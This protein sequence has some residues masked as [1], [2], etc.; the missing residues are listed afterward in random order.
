MTPTLQYT[1]GQWDCAW[2]SIWL[3]WLVGVYKSTPPTDQDGWPRALR[4][5]PYHVA[6]DVSSRWP[7]VGGQ[8]TGG[9]MYN[10]HGARTIQQ[11]LNTNKV[12]LQKNNNSSLTSG[13]NIMNI[14]FTHSI[15]SQPPPWYTQCDNIATVITVCKKP[16]KQQKIYHFPI[17]ATKIKIVPGIV[18]GSTVPGW[19]MQILTRI[20]SV[21]VRNK[22]YKNIQN[23]DAEMPWE[24]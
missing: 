4:E 13:K 7:D 16:M 3:I 9:A 20:L 2:A 17:L 22:V 19:S 6:T 15:S 10:I 24:R 8:V 18:I 23:I 21:N 14:L 1:D 11:S 5:A 12:H